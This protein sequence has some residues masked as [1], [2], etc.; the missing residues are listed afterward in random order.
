MVSLITISGVAEQPEVQTSLEKINGYNIQILGLLC[1][2]KLKGNVTDDI[3]HKLNNI[4]ESIESE[5][6][7]LNKQFKIL[8]SVNKSLNNKL[9]IQQ[10]KIN[11]L[12]HANERALE[13]KKETLPAKNELKRHWTL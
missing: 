7:T 2:V 6:K 12:K 11:L 8:S 3:L 1:K 10:G 4:T 13:L 9:E 5:T